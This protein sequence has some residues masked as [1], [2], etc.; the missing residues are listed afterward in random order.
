MGG[1]YDAQG[2]GVYQFGGYAL[3]KLA[4]GLSRTIDKT[5]Q[6]IDKYD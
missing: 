6:T 1:M 3:K 2:G 4:P 5:K